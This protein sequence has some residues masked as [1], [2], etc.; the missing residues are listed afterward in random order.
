MKHM[1]V[2][3]VSKYDPVK[4]GIEIESRTVRVMIKS[5]VFIS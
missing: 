5:R 2:P 3:K 1:E 4:N